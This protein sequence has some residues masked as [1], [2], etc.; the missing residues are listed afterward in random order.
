MAAG[1]YRRSLL[2]PGQPRTQCWHNP[3]R[4]ICCPKQNHSRKPQHPHPYGEGVPENAGRL[5][6]I[7]SIL[8]PPIARK[9]RD[10]QNPIGPFAPAAQL[11]FASVIQHSRVG[12]LTSSSPITTPSSPAGVASFASRSASSHHAVPPANQPASPPLC[13]PPGIKF[14]RLSPL[15]GP[16][17][18]QRCSLVAPPAWPLRARAIAVADRQPSTP[19]TNVL[20]RPFPP[21]QR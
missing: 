18:L 2:N 8:L 3:Q 9:P 11:R 14:V 6:A 15:R 5:G 13:P 20:S 16:H 1:G 12:C 4:C 19:R 10:T 7:K 21:W 17:L